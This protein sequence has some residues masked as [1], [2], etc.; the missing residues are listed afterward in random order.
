VPRPPESAPEPQASCAR[1]W[2]ACDRVLRSG[3]RPAVEGIGEIPGGG[4][5]NSVTVYIQ[6]WYRELGSRLAA[7]ETP[8]AGFRSEA[9]SRMTELWRLAA[10]GQTRTAETYASSDTASRMLAAEGDALEAEAK[11][12]QA[13]KQEPQRHRSTAEASF[14]EARALLSRREAALEAERSRAA[15]LEQAL[16]QARRDAEM[17]FER[18]RLAPA[19][20]ASSTPS[21]KPKWP[22]RPPAR[23]TKQRQKIGASRPRA[24]ESSSRTPPK[25]AAPSPAPQQEIAQMEP[26]SEALRLLRRQSGLEDAM[27]RPGGIRVVEER[28]IYPLREQLKHHPAAVRA[29]LDAASRPHRP[30]ETLSST[31]V[32]AGQRANRG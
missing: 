30:A 17:L 25:R 11:A 18:Q 12:L 8:L 28:E 19:R 21:R 5:P 29:I 32:E 4:S 14:A 26:L 23:T 22:K 15:S 2:Q 27:R 13:L 3:R 6:E 9:V 10:S 24:N 7:A 1:V 20:T 16:V 31:D